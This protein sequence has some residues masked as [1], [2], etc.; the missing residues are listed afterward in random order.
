LFSF[1]DG[2]AAPAD[3]REERLFETEWPGRIVVVLDASLDTKDKGRGINSTV[4]E[5]P[6]RFLLDARVGGESARLLVSPTSVEGV[7]GVAFD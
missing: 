2:L 4:S 5:K 3:M 1:D 7:L 6:T